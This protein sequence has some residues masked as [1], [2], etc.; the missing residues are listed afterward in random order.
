MAACAGRAE[1]DRELPNCV[2]E[3]LRKG[4]AMADRPNSADPETAGPRDP[5]SLKQNQPDPMLMSSGRMGS[6]GISLIAIAVVVIL[7]VVFYGL[8][9]RMHGTSSPQQQPA[10]MVNSGAP[11]G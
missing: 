2:K 7:A 11:H 10:A 3:T 1:P 4:S 6:G 8:N 5:L 9:G